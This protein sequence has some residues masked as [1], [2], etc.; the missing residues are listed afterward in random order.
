MEGS[1]LRAEEQITSGDVWASCGYEVYASDDGLHLVDRQTYG[2]VAVAAIAASLAVLALLPAVLGDWGRVARAPV[3][4]RSVLLTGA[5]VASLVGLAVGRSARRRGRVP[6]AEIPNSLLIDTRAGCLRDGRGE[7]LAPL[8]C[9]RVSMRIDWWTRGVMCLVRVRW[10][11]GVRTIYRTVSRR[12]A[13]AVVALVA[14]NG[15]A[16]RTRRA[17][18]TT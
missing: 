6:R 15:I 18:P 10:P 4:M 3:V 2:L 16:E 13:R 17:A 9:A 11:D 8:T 5:A 1:I 14:A 12:Q 7:V